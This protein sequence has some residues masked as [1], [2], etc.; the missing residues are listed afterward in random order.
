MNGQNEVLLVCALASRCFGMVLCLPFGEAMQVVPR[1]CLAAVW[2]ISLCGSVSPVGSL[3]AA[4]CL[5]EFASGV[6]IGAPLRLVPDAAEMLGE[7][8]D[9][10]RGQTISSVNDP[11]GSQTQS[12]LAAVSRTAV[13]ALAVHV[14]ALEVLLQELRGS[15][16]LFPL[17]APWQ[18]ATHAESLFQWCVATV[19]G[20]FGLASVWLASFLMVDLVAGIAARLV[21]GLQLS[22]APCLV[23]LLLTCI[24]F[25][26][27]VASIREVPLGSIKAWLC[28]W[29]PSVGSSALSKSPT[30]E[31]GL[32]G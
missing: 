5:W 21:R 6:L 32:E 4:G 18:G 10:A 2:G 1:L 16:D 31:R 9:T 7:L 3:S 27:L 11:L 22:L 25:G 14:G 23:K 13:V 19:G 28:S 26:A 12:D 8:I 29:H 17:G 20:S 24:F 15:Y 30:L